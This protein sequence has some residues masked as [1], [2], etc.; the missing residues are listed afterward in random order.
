MIPT[1]IRYTTASKTRRKAGIIGMNFNRLVR[2]AIA[3][4]GNARTT[5]RPMT[6]AL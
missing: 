1:A 3:V 5:E 6:A 2:Y 4:C